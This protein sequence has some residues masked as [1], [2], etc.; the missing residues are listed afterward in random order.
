MEAS[1]SEGTSPMIE[2]DAQE[3]GLHLKQ[4]GWRLGLLVARDVEPGVGSGTRTDLGA[5]IPRLG[6]GK[7]SAETFAEMAKSTSQRVMRY[8]R[9][10]ERYADRGRVPHAADLSPGDEPDLNWDLLPHW[11][12]SDIQSHGATGPLNLRIKLGQYGERLL[13]SHKRLIHFIDK[14]LVNAK[15]STKDARKLAERYADC[16][17][18]EAQVLRAFAAGELPEREEV[19]NMLEPSKFFT[20]A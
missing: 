5:S 6:E 13:R 1:V 12:L 10:W 7:V 3:F 16:L 15:G 4:G 14:D 8:Y 2:L 19:K 20:T 18:T 9:A 11:T 17:E